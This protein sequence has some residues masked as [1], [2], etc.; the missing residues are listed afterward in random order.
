VSPLIPCGF[1]DV[2]S[3]TEARFGADTLVALLCV[4]AGLGT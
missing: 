4:N 3:G 1:R 2:D